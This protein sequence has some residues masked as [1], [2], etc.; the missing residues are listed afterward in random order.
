MTKFEEISNKITFLEEKHKYFLGKK[1][2]ISVTTLLNHYKNKFDPEGHILR[3][4]A[5]RDGI[6]TVKLK[7]KWNKE[8]DDA[9]ERGNRLHSQL[10]YFIKTK[11]ILDEDY[12]EVVE[13]F[14]KI[15]FNGELYS[16]TK[17][18]SKNFNI[19]GT[20][21]F[22]ELLNNDTINI[23]DFKQNK[24]IRLES[25]YDNKL[26]YPLDSYEEC[27][28]NI[29]TFQINLYSYILKE[30]GYKTNKMTLYYFPPLKNI[31]EIFNIPKKEEET[32]KLLEHF[33]LINNI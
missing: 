22:I 13:Q 17:I 3:A 25:K 12:K 14:S 29:Y 30:H 7:E 20:V 16:E 19:A 32:I 21:D 9:C 11:E 31:I 27:E 28:F 5:K 10:E 23:G 8:R 18:F 2:L 24:K 15:K 1:E 33:N 26:I 4:C 6:S